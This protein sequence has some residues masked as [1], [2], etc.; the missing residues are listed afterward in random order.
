MTYQDVL[1]RLK[2]ERLRNQWSQMRMGQCMRMSQSHY[3]KAELGFRRLTYYELQFLCDS[4][5]DVHFVFTG[6]KRENSDYGFF[7]SCDYTE[8]ICILK[9]LYFTFEY[10]Y[11][12][13]SVY[14]DQAYKR[15][16]YMKYVVFSRDFNRNML[17][18]IRKVEDCTQ[19]KMAEIL[20]VDI[21]KLR[22]LENGNRRPDSELLF[23]I[24]RAFHVPPAVLLKDRDGIASEISC[25][26]DLMSEKQRIDAVRYLEA[27]HDA[28]SSS[29]V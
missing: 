23:R 11:R 3:S 22:D 26:L 12:N 7:Q 14:G 20:E 10:F 27:C 2:Q 8:L 25:L 29:A 4:E 13:K 1:R 18:D 19:F 24:Y 21:K 9:I 16:E 28:L 6:N 5:I 15:A 17:H